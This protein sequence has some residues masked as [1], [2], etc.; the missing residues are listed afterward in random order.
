M[1]LPVQ[2]CPTYRRKPVSDTRA[3]MDRLHELLARSAA[4]WG[5]AVDPIPASYDVA[6]Y[7]VGRSGVLA[8]VEGYALCG[9]EPDDRRAPRDAY[10]LLGERLRDHGPTRHMVYPLN[11]ESVRLTRKLGAVPQGVDAD[12]YVHYIL[13]YAGYRA[14]AAKH[15]GRRCP[16]HLL[17]E[18][19]HGPQIPDSSTQPTA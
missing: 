8:F 16:Q 4:R 1:R 9:W 13:T 15:L 2:T 6:A 12:G 18:T 17:P 19:P 11:L 7:P 3:L 14:A 5:E 10:R